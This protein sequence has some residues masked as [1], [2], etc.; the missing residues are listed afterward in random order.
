MPIMG[1]DV[2]SADGELDFFALKHAGVKFAFVRATVGCSRSDPR[3]CENLRGFEKYAIP[4][5]AF[6][7]LRAGDLIE[8]AREAEFFIEALE[9]QRERLPLFAVCR[10]PEIQPDR[11][12]DGIAKLTAL[13]CRRLSGAGFSPCVYTSAGFYRELEARSELFSGLCEEFPPLW[14]SYPGAPGQTGGAAHPAVRQYRLAGTIEGCK[15]V[16]NLNFGWERLAEPI[17]S[18]R[19][20]LGQSFFRHAL[21]NDPDGGLLVKLADRVTG[22]SLKPIRSPDF[23][24][25]LTLIRWQCGLTAAETACL[26]SYPGSEEAVRAVYAAITG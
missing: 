17:L 23:P 13:F 15:G 21:E 7:E 10:L 9:P 24:K 2:S 22:R 6:H 12:F 8:A 20:G 3:F 26:G 11:N 1:I 5:G 25:L 14:E 18:S 4:A 19:C 16:F